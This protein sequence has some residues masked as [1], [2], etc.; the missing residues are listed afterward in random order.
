MTPRTGK[1]IGSFM[2]SRLGSSNGAPHRLKGSVHAV[3][4]Q[5]DEYRLDTGTHIEL[6]QDMPNV[7]ADRRKRHEKTQGDAGA[8]QLPQQRKH[9]LAEI[10]Q[11]N[12]LK[13]DA[14]DVAYEP[15]LIVRCSQPL[16]EFAKI[17]VEANTGFAPTCN[18]S[19]SRRRC[20][21]WNGCLEP[22]LFESKIPGRYRLEV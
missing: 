5:G 15:C 19:Q 13:G 6:L 3:D 18:Y 2:K 22:R 9:A 14:K 7:G 16:D 1:E 20:A 10:V 21:R 12:R 17:F 4:A 11:G 8:K